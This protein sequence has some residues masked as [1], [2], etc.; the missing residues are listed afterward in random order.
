MRRVIKIGGSLLTRNDLTLAIDSWIGGEPPATNI[1]IVGGGHRIDAV[2]QADAL[3]PSNPADVHWRCIDLLDTTYEFIRDRFPRW[4]HIRSAE[5]FE[6]CVERGFP[7]HC[8]SL[9]KVA[10]FYGPSSDAPLPCD[11]QTTTDAIAM[12]L[13]NRLDADEVVLLKS[14]D[15]NPAL[16]VDQLSALEIIDRAAAKLD[17][18]FG[19]LRVEKLPEV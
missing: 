8:V 19:K 1:V 14:C 11:W 6:R 9:V 15:V 16:S 13:G 12:W 5:A 4:Q 10:A 7:D 18:Q 3:R 2:R 17:Q